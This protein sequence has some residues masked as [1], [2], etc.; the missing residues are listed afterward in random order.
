MRI[1]SHFM[2]HAEKQLLAASPFK[3]TVRKPLF[4]QLLFTEEGGGDILK[5][6]SFCED[7]LPRPKTVRVAS[8]SFNR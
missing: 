7:P 1:R 3:P 6:K 4:D 8:P 5:D 2:A